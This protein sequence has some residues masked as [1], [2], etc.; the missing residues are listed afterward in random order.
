M[1]KAARIATTLALGLA[2]AMPAGAASD[3]EEPAGD[4]FI[5]RLADAAEQNGGGL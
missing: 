4:S 3:N 1:I 5:S 2:L